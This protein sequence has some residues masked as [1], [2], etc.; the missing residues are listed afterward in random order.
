MMAADPGGGLAVSDDRIAVCVAGAV[1]DG[2]GA[3]GAVNGIADQLRHAGFTARRIMD[4]PMN[5]AAEKLA[6]FLPPH[7]LARP[8]T[9]LIIWWAGRGSFEH[10]SGALRLYVREDQVREVR[11]EFMVI[12]AGQLA[13]LA[14]ETGAAQI[15]FVLDVD[16]HEGATGED[17]AHVI[18]EVSQE[19]ER[20]A[21]WHGC[22]VSRA[23]GAGLTHL[24]GKLMSHGPN[25]N[26]LR[27]RWA[28]EPEVRGDD[29]MD[30]LI[31]E[32]PVGAEPLY[33]YSGRPQPL[34]AHPPWFLSIMMKDGELPV[35]PEGVARAFVSYVREDAATVERIAQ[36]LTSAGIP[37]WR[38]VEEL[39]GGTRWR[40]AIRAAI[41][42]GSAFV[43]FFSNASERREK[44]YMREEL[45]EAVAE[46]RLRTQDRPWLIPVRLSPCEIPAIAVA[47][48]ETLQDLHYVDIF[49]SDD[50]SAVARLVDALQA[51]RMPSAQ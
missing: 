26:N 42:S 48:N 3:T 50:E 16:V 6:S 35:S 4:T 44:S 17:F 32:S 28:N 23:G 39:V 15:L 45:L 38:D 30:A 7:S 14:V 27:V 8:A 9:K 22:A 29:L 11:P 49:D 18:E 10:E 31:K 51:A 41:A 37:V 12:T 25:D 5:P 13:A 46:L 36:H 19:L 33:A 43:A 47:G 24:F 34:L 1:P 2:V 20:G 40:Q 21:G